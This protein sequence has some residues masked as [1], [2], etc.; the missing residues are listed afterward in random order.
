L[1][2]IA[3]LKSPSVVHTFQKGA[4][5]K[6]FVVIGPSEVYEGETVQFL[7][8]A[9]YINPDNTLAARNVTTDNVSEFA[10]LSGDFNLDGSIDVVDLSILATYYGKPANGWIQGDT[11]LDGK[12]DLMDLSLMASNYGTRYRDPPVWHISP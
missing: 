10:L 3:S 5:L 1:K 2:D 11:N 12:T 4:V 8:I 7:G 9:I 6:D